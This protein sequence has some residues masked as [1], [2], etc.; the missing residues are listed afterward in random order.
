MMPSLKYALLLI[1]LTIVSLPTAEAVVHPA[2]TAT[3]SSTEARANEDNDR[4]AT[5][6]ERRAERRELR[7][8][9]QALRQ[10]RRELR[11]NLWQEYKAARRD[12]DPEAEAILLIILALFLAPVAMFIYE[13]G[14][15]FRFYVSLAL[16][17]GG[18]VIAWIP[19][20]GLLGGL[21]ILASIVYTIVTIVAGSF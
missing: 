10:A 7:A 18:I 5:R 17:L 3:E 13:R 11:R 19:L 12:G 6:N 15:T 8:E 4:Q 20:L 1:V 14:D 21:L 16:F 2:P 9:R